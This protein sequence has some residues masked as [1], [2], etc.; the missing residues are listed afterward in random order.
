M[1]TLMRMLDLP[2]ESSLI[3]LPVL[4]LRMQAESRPELMTALATTV[5]GYRRFEQHYPRVV[6]AAK[7][8]SLPHQTS[9]SAVFT[10]PD[11]AAGDHPSLPTRC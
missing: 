11:D 8:L 7:R 6:D 1:A 5:Y 2:Q 4:Q 10:S 9:R 3:Y